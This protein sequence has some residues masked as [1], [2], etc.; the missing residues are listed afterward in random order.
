[1][2]SVNI[3]HS[4]RWFTTTY[5]Y[6]IWVYYDGNWFILYIDVCVC[7]CVCVCERDPS[8]L[9]LYFLSNSYLCIYLELSK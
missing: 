7:V 8:N 9:L 6:G 5:I 1:M 2:N 3:T 4:I